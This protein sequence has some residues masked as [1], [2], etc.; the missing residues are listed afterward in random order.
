VR[1]LVA[2]FWGMAS[3]PDCTAD[4]VVRLAREATAQAS[5]NRWPTGPLVELDHYPPADTGSWTTPLVRDPFQVSVEEKMD[6]LQD[7]VGAAEQLGLQ[8]VTLTTQLTFRRQEKV[9]ASTT[10][11]YVTQT[12]SWVGPSDIA[13]TLTNPTTQAQQQLVA[14][15]VPLQ[16]GGYE[17]V[18]S[19]RPH[20][21]LAG[22]VEE[23]RGQRWTMPIPIGKFP[24]V[25]DAYTT[26]ALVRSTFGYATELDRVRG[27]EVNAGG[28]SYLTEASLG[29]SIA[30]P[31]VTVTGSRSEPHGPA[32]T[33]WDDEGVAPHPFPLVR[34]GTL[35]DF[36]TSRADAPQLSTWYAQH[37]QP[38]RSHGCAV[39][40]TAAD[41]PVVMP[42]DLTL[43]PGTA[44]TSFEQ[45]IAT[46]RQG[47]AVVRGECDL[48]RAQWSGQGSGTMYEIRNGTL[49]RYLGPSAAF[50]FRSTELWHNVLALGGPS[51]ARLRGFRST[52][53]QPEQTA[54]H[55]V[56]AVPMAVNNMVVFD[57]LR[58]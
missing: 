49:G 31:M 56:W 2:G 19:L 44:D 12:L 46:I 32:M 45:L 41:L 58:I 11:A 25:L 50:R 21:Q 1:A 18:A 47:F 36:A 3:A 42:P 54:S 39:A 51:S 10:N 8:D 34:D 27:D 28:T 35:V 6:F 57:A 5:V 30:H 38:V 26:A 53:G 9:F 15:V 29:Q 43:H 13:V 52:K 20:D 7:C 17:Q 33:G 55:G 4:S 37:Q 22:W 23:V 48:D 40:D 16:S 14:P 24:L